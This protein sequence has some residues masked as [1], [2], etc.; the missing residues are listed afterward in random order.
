MTWPSMSPNL[1]PTEH[2]WGYFKEKCRASQA[3]QERAAAA[4]NKEEEEEE[5]NVFPEICEHWYPF[6]C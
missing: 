6:L 3:L 1:N 4:V 5:P 2:L